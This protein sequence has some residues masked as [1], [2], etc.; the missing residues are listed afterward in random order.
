MN[1]DDRNEH[2]RRFDARVAE[3]KA[4]IAALIEPHTLSVLAAW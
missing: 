3:T 4:G 2:Q 1:D